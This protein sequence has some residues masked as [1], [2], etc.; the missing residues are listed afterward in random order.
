VKPDDEKLLIVIRNWRKYQR[1]LKGD[2]RHRTWFAVS[3]NIAHDPDFMSLPVA[4][5]YAWLMVLA[6]A[7]LRG[8]EDE[9]GSCLLQVC[10][11][12]FRTLYGLRNNFVF[13]SLENQGFIE[14][15]K[16][17]EQ[18]RTVQ[19]KTVALDAQASVPDAPKKKPKPPKEPDPN[20]DAF[21]QA[22]PLKV[23]KVAAA[24]EWAKKPR[25]SA[26]L[27][28]DIAARLNN[29][30]Q[31]QP[32]SQ[33]IPHARTYLSQE[34]WN[35]AIQ[36]IVNQPAR[37]VKP[38]TDSDWLKLANDHGIRTKGKGY[39]EIWNEFLSKRGAAA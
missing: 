38:T 3:A 21:W 36:P 34:R 25:D 29:D 32:G 9:L 13:S 39:N 8:V 27:I 2:S 14:I 26:A 18:N 33:F 28:M 5:R 20:F 4:D 23:G 22:Y 11:K 30:R 16:P 31:W 1:Q 10:P 37:V 35:D 12:L 24:K 17:T 19:N 7:S 6:D 15:R